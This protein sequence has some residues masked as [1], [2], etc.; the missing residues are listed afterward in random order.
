MKIYQWFTLLLLFILSATGC[1]KE[2]LGGLGEVKLY[3]PNII[4]TS[5]D[6]NNIFYPQ[7]SIENPDVSLTVETMEIFDRF[8]NSIYKAVQF[9][10]NDIFYGWNG[11]LYGELVEPGTYVYSIKISDGIGSILFTGDVGVLR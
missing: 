4:T 6:I 2:D 8:G 11:T 3:L 10:P 1:G 5:G 9:P 7:V